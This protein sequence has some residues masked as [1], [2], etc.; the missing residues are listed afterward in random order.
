M[1]A[2]ILDEV[3]Y[4]YAVNVAERAMRHMLEHRIP[5]TPENFRVWTSYAQGVP[6]DLKRTIDI[7]IGNKRTFDSR[8]NQELAATFATASTSEIAG[9]SQQL[10]SVVDAAREFLSAAIADNRSQIRSIGDV[11][12]AAQGGADPKVL[13]ESLVKELG[14]AAARAADLERSFAASS[15]ELDTIRDSLQKAEEHSR[16]DMLTGL[17]NRR[18]LDEFLRLAQTAAMENGTPLGMLL[19][20]VDHF[21]RFNDDFGHNVGDQVL[22]LLGGVLKDRVRD[23]DLAARYG[24][25]ELI[26]VLPAADMDTCAA[27]AERIRKSIAECKITRRASGEVLPSISVSIG[28]AQFRPGEPV[29]DFIERCDSAL[30]MAKRSGRNR[31]VTE[32]QLDP[33]LLA[34]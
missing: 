1:T 20:D 18:A 13:V 4:D 17:P 32:L 34:S 19:I 29:T 14:K 33:D 7:L 26:A 27:V 8:T 31:V 30:Y 24:G 9:A 6:A 15:R 25:E 21:K 5:P 28:V 16:T 11:A 23:N 3:D 2:A 10:S 22:K 12:G